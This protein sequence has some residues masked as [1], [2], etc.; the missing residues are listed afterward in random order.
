MEEIY[1]PVPTTENIT[2][3]KNSEFISFN[4]ELEKV[5]YWAFCV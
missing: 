4:L 3:I 5:P 2:S 1:W